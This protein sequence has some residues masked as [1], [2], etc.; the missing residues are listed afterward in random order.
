[1]GLMLLP[2]SVIAGVLWDKV[3]TAAPFYFGA[4]LAFV[5]MLGLLL[6]HKEK[7]QKLT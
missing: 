2:A 6:F 5:A 1:V 3:N 7:R 4:G